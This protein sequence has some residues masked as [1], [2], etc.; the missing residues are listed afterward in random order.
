[1]K[2]AQLIASGAEVTAVEA[3]VPRIKRLKDNLSRLKL[4][5]NVL[6]AD[7]FEFQ[8]DALFD[9]VLLDAPCSS[10]GTIRRHPDIPWTKSKQEVEKLAELQF[11]MIIKASE[12]VRKEGILVFSNCS[13]DRMEG[14]DLVA[15][16]G[17][18]LPQ[19]KLDPITPEDVF[20][21]K[22][23]I[24]GQGTVRTL[25]CH[26][27][28]LDGLETIPGEQQSAFSG[29]DGFFAARFIRSTG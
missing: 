23:F 6:E 21:Q 11:R 9:A 29:L 25:P 2:T 24:S 12:F 8:P 3:S 22:Q 26:L 17:R 4:Q 28:S 15:R 18:E 13:I 20:H 5:A 7:L 16:L 19:L 14:E 1:M 10:T 27:N